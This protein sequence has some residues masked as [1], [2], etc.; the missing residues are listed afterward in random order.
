M[1]EPDLRPPR[2]PQAPPAARFAPEAWILGALAEGVFVLSLDDLRFLYTNPAFD[3]MFGYAAGELL[4]QPVSRINAPG[5]GPPEETAR[6]ILDLLLG[7]GRWDGDVLSLRKD[8]STFRTY[9]TATVHDLPGWGRVVVAIQRDVGSV[10]GA[11]AELRLRGVYVATLLDHF[12]FPAWMKDPQGR[13]L[14]AN[15]ALAEAAGMADPEMLLGMDDPGGLPADLAAHMRLGERRAIASARPTVRDCRVEQRGIVRW[16]EVFHSPIRLQD[17]TIGVLGFARDV[18]DRQAAAEALRE[19][20]RWLHAILDQLPVGVSLFDSQGHVV[21]DNASMRGFNDSDR[22]PSISRRQ[23]P[24]WQAR[25]ADGTVLDPS[26]WPGARA[27]R[28]ESVRQGIEFEHRGSDGSLRTVLVS[29][30]PFHAGEGPMAVAVAVAQDISERKLA[31]AALRESEQQLRIIADH[32]PD[33]IFHIDREHRI[34]YLNAPTVHWLARVLGRPELHLDELRGR[35]VWE[36]LGDTEMS[37]GYR[38]HS[39]QVMRSGRPDSVEESVLIDGVLRTRLILRTPVRDPAGEVVGLLGIARDISDRRQQELAHL[40]QLHEQRDALV[41]EVHHRI[42]NHLQGVL[43]LLRLRIDRHPDLRE[44]LAEVMAQIHA[45]AGVYGLSQGPAGTDADLLGIIGLVVQGAAAGVPLRFEP[46]VH[47]SMA[48]RE[49]DAVPIALVI[50]ELL[51]NASKHLAEQDP[52]RPVRI[53]LHGDQQGLWVRV[54][55]GPAWLPPEFD[56]ASGRGL[57]TGL[58]LLRTLLPSQGARLSI[59]QEADEVL[60]ELLL[61]EPVVRPR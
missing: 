25:C 41:R 16:W 15:Q 13:F 32:H 19:R 28:G 59:R 48:L 39:E 22:I 58:Q 1:D 30:V 18:S 53:T 8:G 50:N 46:G 11:E 33:G 6:A 60:A 34:L 4:G 51:S 44:P 47:P 36:I 17:S 10:R 42:K 27:L 52:E 21:L 38:H 43:G 35:R 24:R 37:L 55:N 61:Q 26:Q 40:Q 49:A 3:A 7:S 12:P 14:A 54:R 56:F 2:P 31:E 29:A 45:I 5:A 23:R 20:Q 57:G 9:N